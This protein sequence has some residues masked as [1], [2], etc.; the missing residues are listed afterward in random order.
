MRYMLVAILLCT[1]SGCVP[2]MAGAITH[3]ALERNSDRK[4]WQEKHRHQEKMRELDL[5]EKWMKMQQPQ[6]PTYPT[7][8]TYPTD[9]GIV[10]ESPF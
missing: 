5:Q 7:Y 8:P 3:N 2:L 6:A 9:A 1:T 4:E 10:R